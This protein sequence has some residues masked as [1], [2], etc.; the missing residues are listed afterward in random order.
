[1]A[2]HVYL[3]SRAVSR[4]P[5][6]SRSSRRLERSG[7]PPRLLSRQSSSSLSWSAVA[8]LIPLRHRPLFPRR[9]SSHPTASLTSSPL[10]SHGE[11]GDATHIVARPSARAAPS[12]QIGRIP[13]SGI[14]REYSPPGRPIPL[15]PT[16]QTPKK[17]RPPCRGC[18]STHLPLSHSPHGTLDR[19]GTRVQVPN[20]TIN[21]MKEAYLD[22]TDRGDE[23]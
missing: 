13:P 21:S 8:D 4:S 10:F 23:L 1:M 17:N 3:R 15:P 22:T 2:G 19:A 20:S 16:N 5:S 7:S 9:P 18:K 6:S 14:W 11:R 12:G